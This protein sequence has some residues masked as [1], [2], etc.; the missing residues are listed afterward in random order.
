MKTILQFWPFLLSIEPTFWSLF[1]FYEQLVNIFK[2]VTPVNEAEEK[3]N[4]WFHGY[5]VSN[6]IEK[7]I[8]KKIRSVELL[9]DGQIHKNR[10]HIKNCIKKKKM[11]LFRGIIDS[12]R[13]S[14][15]LKH[16]SLLEKNILFMYLSGRWNKFRVCLLQNIVNTQI[17]YWEALI[18]SVGL[19]GVESVWKCYN[20]FDMF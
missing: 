1:W 13:G 15:T 10:R 7:E 14:N 16:P 5:V 12:I 3:A 2:Q 20:T 6:R 17:T 8:I 9:I 19:F 4:Y 11:T 18:A